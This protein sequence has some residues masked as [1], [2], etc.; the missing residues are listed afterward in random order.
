MSPARRRVP[1]AGEVV[2]RGFGD[3]TVL[4][5]SAAGLQRARDRLGPMA[6]QIHSLT[7]DILRWCPER[8]C[9]AWHDSAAYVA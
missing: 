7:A 4:D 2:D 1:L 6:D 5:I 3:V 8:H 9:G